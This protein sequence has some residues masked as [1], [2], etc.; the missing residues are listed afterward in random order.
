MSISA[1]HNGLIMPSLVWLA[2]IAAAFFGAYVK[3]V[4][5]MSI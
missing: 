1:R 3:G 2:A 4:D 5:I